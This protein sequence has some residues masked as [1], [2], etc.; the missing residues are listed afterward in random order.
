[1]DH[2]RVLDAKRYAQDYNVT[3]IH[4]ETAL[5]ATLQA[6]GIAPTPEFFKEFMQIVTTFHPKKFALALQ[7]V[8]RTP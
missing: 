7:P 8:R 6:N 1:M 4:V 2:L 5:A 3:R